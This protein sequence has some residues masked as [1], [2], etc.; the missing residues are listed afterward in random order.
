MKHESNGA[1]KRL[2]NDDRGGS[3]T[4]NRTRQNRHRPSLLFR[5]FQPTQRARS[6]SLTQTFTR[7]PG[8]TNNGTMKEGIRGNR[9]P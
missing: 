5:D 2:L 9:E 8:A 3:S 6:S 7:Q 1:N 4:S